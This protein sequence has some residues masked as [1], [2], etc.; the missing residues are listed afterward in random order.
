MCKVDELD[1][2]A[3][4]A[5]IGNQYQHIVGLNDA[6]V[7]MLSLARMKEEGRRACRCQ[8]CGDI[9]ANLS[10]LAHSAHHDLAPA[11]MNVFD[12]KIHCFLVVVVQWNV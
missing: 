11:V 4:L 1:D 6:K 7:S 3:G 12:D 8:C 5:R 2:L 10:G 9:G